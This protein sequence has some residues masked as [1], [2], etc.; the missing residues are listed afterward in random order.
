MQN[1]IFPASNIPRNNQKII[2]LHKGVEQEIEIPWWV[3]TPE[4]IEAKKKV[5]E[6]QFFLLRQGSMGEVF[7]CS[8]CKEK[9]K[10]FTLMCIDRPFDGLTEG[11]YAYWYHTGKHNVENF[12]SDVELQRYYAIREV[13]NKSGQYPD[14]ATSHPRL[15]ESLGTPITDFD[16]GS[17]ALGIL[18]PITKQKAQALAWNINARGLKPPL[19]LKGLNDAAV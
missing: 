12:L 2:L 13:L 17:V 18:E 5:Q 1:G 6:S 10:Y 11:L 8:R 7:R 3:I 4:Q 9:H 14:V 19:K 16:A 15:A